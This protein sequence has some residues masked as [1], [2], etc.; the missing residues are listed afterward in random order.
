MTNLTPSTR[1]F[2]L[3]AEHPFLEAFLKAYNPRYKVLESRA[4]RAS[5]GRVA[6]LRMVAAMGGVPLDQLI[7]DLSDAIKAETGQRPTTSLARD[8]SGEEDEVLTALKD[9][10]HRLHA[11]EKLETLRVEHAEALSRLDPMAIADLEQRLLEE[12]LP[13]EELQQMC[14]LHVELF[15]SSLEDLEAPTTPAGHPLHT[16]MAENRALLSLLER[17]EASL[18]GDLDLSDLGAQLDAIAQVEL[19]YQRKENQLFPYLEHKDFSGP[20]LVMW[21][22]HD[23]VR[24][25]LKSMRAGLAL[26][27]PTIVRQRS[28]ELSRGLRQMVHLEEKV[29]AGAAL[30]LLDDS[31]WLEVWRG[32]PEIGFAWVDRGDEWPP[33]E[34]KEPQEQT[35]AGLLPLRTGALSLDQVDM[36]LRHLP[37]DLSFVDEHDRVRYYT[38]VQHRIFPRSSSVIGRAV[39]K[40][41]PPKSVHMVQAILDAFRAGEQDQAR[42]WLELGGRFLLIQ[43]FAMREED[44]TYTGCLEVSQDV[45]DI[46]TLEGERRL[47]EWE[48]GS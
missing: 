23:E 6:S 34:L 43:Y 25:L 33:A 40:C 16:L 2:A 4:M 20:S 7:R 39:Q 14:H 31:E 5:V 24:G 11:G 35:H 26:G 12:G 21:G 9:I 15:K 29:L 44:G 27:E 47:L 13:E 19:H 17:W 30:G 32:E 22:V 41:H 18:T 37:L 10:I 42:F 36:M 46:R 1:L 3:L 45:T 28:L 8:A 48:A 38:D